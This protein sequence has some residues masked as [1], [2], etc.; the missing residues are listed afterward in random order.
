MTTEG[1]SLAA[2]VTRWK[3]IAEE[4]GR[5]GIVLYQ[6]PDGQTSIDV[7]LENDM[8]W[9]TQAQICMLLPPMEKSYTTNYNNLDVI[10]SSIG[11]I[12]Q[13]WDRKDLYPS[14]PMHFPGRKNKRAT[15]KEA[16]IKSVSFVRCVWGSNP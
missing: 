15:K 3:T 13:T 12:H 2:L 16:E 9:L 4:N 6:T 1:F 5:G 11:Q 14:E 10:K 7:K 8:V